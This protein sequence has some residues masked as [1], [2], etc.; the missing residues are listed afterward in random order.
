MRDS[1]ERFTAKLFLHGTLPACKLEIEDDTNR[2]KMA[3]SSW[4]VHNA[5]QVEKPRESCG[6]WKRLIGVVHP[7]GN[8]VIKFRNAACAVTIRPW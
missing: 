2:D 4:T 3:P 6:L 1:R 5:L 7:L 8:L